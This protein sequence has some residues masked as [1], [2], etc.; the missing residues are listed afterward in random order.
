MREHIRVNTNNQTIN[1]SHTLI[2]QDKFREV[3][4]IYKKT[5]PNGFSD[6]KV[7]A[8]EKHINFGNFLKKKEI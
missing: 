6:K 4:L 5:H 2:T 1:L 3:P 7:T 8:C